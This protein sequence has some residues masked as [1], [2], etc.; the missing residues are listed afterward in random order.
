MYIPPCL[1]EFEFYVY[2]A[3][4]M[5]PSWAPPPPM[6]VFFSLNPDIY[7]KCTSLGIIQVLTVNEC[8]LLPSTSSRFSPGHH[9]ACIDICIDLPSIRTADKRPRDA[10]R[11]LPQSFSMI[12][13]EFSFGQFILG[14]ALRALLPIS[15]T[16]PNQIPCPR[17]DHGDTGHE[18]CFRP[19]PCLAV[20]L[21][22][23]AHRYL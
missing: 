20:H 11:R 23:L 6:M 8:I 3:T 17:D 12:M 1:V 7:I 5:A 9:R 16:D 18:I 13:I 10:R 2:S 14:V 4:S 19:E 22:I 15:A 21:R